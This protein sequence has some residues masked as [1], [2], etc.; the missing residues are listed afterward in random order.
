MSLRHGLRRVGLLLLV[1]VA[2][3]SVAG[4]GS[5]SSSS[6]SSSS[7]SGTTPK[8]VHFAKTKFLLHAGLAFGAFH[9]Y[10][11]K[12]FRA[13]S[14]SDPLHHKVALVR[15]AAAGLFVV[16]E[17]RQASAAAQGSAVLRK[18]TSPL[19][20][21]A[22]T[23]TGFA[24]RAKG[25]QLDSGALDSANGAIDTIRNGASSAGAAITERAPPVNP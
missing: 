7:G 16:H 5:R 6:G 21:L 18:L 1:V 25:G 10:L 3:A 22:A 20:A 19:T 2:L 14:F 15:G 17:V 23:V 9:R 4:C 8:I 24:T 13:G 11:Y 12:P